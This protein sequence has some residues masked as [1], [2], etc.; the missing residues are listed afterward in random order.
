[1]LFHGDN[2]ECLSTLLTSGFRGKVDL[3]Y[4][5]P[6]FDSKADYVK[7]IEESIIWDL[8]NRAPEQVKS[9]GFVVFMEKMNI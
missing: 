2:K 1:L 3:I 9:P 4:I 6:P 8:N 5:D 7:K